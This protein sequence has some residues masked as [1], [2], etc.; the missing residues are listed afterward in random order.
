MKLQ[1]ANL[2]GHEIVK[3]M[4]RLRGYMK[5]LQATQQAGS[6]AEPTLKLNKAAAKRFVQSSLSTPVEAQQSKAEKEEQEEDLDEAEDG[7]GNE[8][9]M[10]ESEDA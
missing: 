1:N 6:A 2:A 5:K 4:E 9:S 7:S 3:D 10:D 8:E